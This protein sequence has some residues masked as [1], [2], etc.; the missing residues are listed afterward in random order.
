[1]RT[2][3]L[4]VVVSLFLFGHMFRIIMDIQEL[5]DLSKGKDNPYVENEC[6]SGCASP[7]SLWSNVSISI[8]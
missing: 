1:M 4:F 6:D 7:F 5:I 8:E 2:R 3:T